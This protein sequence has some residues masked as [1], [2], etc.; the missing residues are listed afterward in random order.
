M[1]KRPIVLKTV[2]RENHLVLQDNVVKL[3]ALFRGYSIRKKFKQSN[4]LFANISPVEAEN[5]VNISPELVVD[6]NSKPV[7]IYTS[8]LDMNIEKGNKIN[9]AKINIQTDAQINPEV[10][11]K[12]EC[13]SE[14]IEVREID[15]VKELPLSNGTVYSGTFLIIQRP[16]DKRS[17]RWLRSAIMA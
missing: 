6:I 2:P 13:K 5:S 1:D 17:A 14:S 4:T 7:N 12:Q 11:P 10:N 3:Q 8:V 9:K 15:H 16:N